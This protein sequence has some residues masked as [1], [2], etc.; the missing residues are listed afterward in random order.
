[1]AEISSANQSTL[2]PGSIGVPPQQ[3]HYV[4]SNLGSAVSSSMHLTNSSHD[5]DGGVS[6]YKMD[7]EMMYYSVSTLSNELSNT[8][9]NKY[10]SNLN[11]YVS[12][13]V[14]E[15]IIWIKPHHWWFYQCNFKW[16]WFTYGHGSQWR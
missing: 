11:K 7:S 16:W 3:P 4:G 5:S 2:P 8:I 1:M 15:Y 14:T 13:F 9:L 6:G 12:I 10:F